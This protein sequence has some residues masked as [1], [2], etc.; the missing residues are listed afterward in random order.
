M[1]KNIACVFGGIVAGVAICLTAAMLIPI[2]D[3]HEVDGFFQSVR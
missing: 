2:N 3:E 1:I